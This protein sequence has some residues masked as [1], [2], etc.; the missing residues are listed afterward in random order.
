MFVYPFEVSVV[1]FGDA[2]GFKK[3]DTGLLIF[4]S[5]P[6]R[7]SIIHQIKSYIYRIS[8]SDPIFNFNEKKSS[9]KLTRKGSVSDQ[10]IKCK[11]L[12]GIYW[13]STDS[14]TTLSS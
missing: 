10:L 3:L 7:T 2:G 4:G 1:V 5:C 13:L 6:A 12:I 11:L 8:V 14:K 9:D